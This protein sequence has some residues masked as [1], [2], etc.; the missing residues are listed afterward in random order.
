MQIGVVSCNLLKLGDF[1]Q[2]GALWY[3]LV[4]LGTTWCSLEQLGAG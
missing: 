3:S 1:G 2:R 4:E